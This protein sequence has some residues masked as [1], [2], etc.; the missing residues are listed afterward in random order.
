[1]DAQ[2]KKSDVLTEKRR[3]KEFR[4]S[5]D[6]L[7]QYRI[8]VLME[9]EDGT[10]EIGDFKLGLHEYSYGDNTFVYTW[11]MPVFRHFAFGES[12]DEFLQ[13]LFERRTEQEFKNIVFSIQKKQGQIIQVNYE[14]NMIVQGCARSGKSMIMLHR[15]PILLYDNPKIIDRNRIY[16]ITPSLTYMKMAEKMRKQLE[17]ED[18]N[19][20]T[21]NQYFDYCIRKY[22]KHKSDYGKINKQIK[23]ILNN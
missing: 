8:G 12:N 3:L 10:L 19:M 23:L 7:Y 17:I 1:M 4:D 9:D 16:I 6:E 14:Q 15:I 18:L 13:E 2:K 5:N 21:I 22:G 11:K 20:G